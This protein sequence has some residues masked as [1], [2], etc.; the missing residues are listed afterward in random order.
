MTRAPGVAL[1]PVTFVTFDR[2]RNHRAGTFETVVASES[3][4]RVVQVHVQYD[5]IVVSPVR[6]VGRSAAI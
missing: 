2:P 5:V 3:Q 6:H 1:G 4:H